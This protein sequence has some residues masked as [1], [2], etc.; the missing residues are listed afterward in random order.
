MA[1]QRLR[2]LRVDRSRT[3][4]RT[5]SGRSR[6]STRSRVASAH[7]PLAH[8]RHRARRRVHDLVQRDVEAQV[9][10]RQRPLRLERVDVRD[11]EAEAGLVAVGR[12][13]WAAA[14]RSDRARA[15]R[16]SRSSSRPARR[17]ARARASDSML[18]MPGMPAMARRACSRSRERRRTAPRSASGSSSSS[19]CIAS[20][21]VVASA[22]STGRSATRWRSTHPFGP[23]VARASWRRWR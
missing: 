21:S 17:G 10:A 22:S 16:G 5:P 3:R 14:G 15:A 18:P 13:R 20:P 4:P 1:L 9:V 7:E 2:V 12:R 23:T 11:D 6:S 8:P 19:C